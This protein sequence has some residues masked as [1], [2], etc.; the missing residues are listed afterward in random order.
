MNN[1]K[2]IISGEITCFSGSPQATPEGYCQEIFLNTKQKS[3]NTQCAC[4]YKKIHNNNYL[5]FTH[6]AFAS[7]SLN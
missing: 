1:S 5:Y 2:H 6:F 3:A 4:F 7:F